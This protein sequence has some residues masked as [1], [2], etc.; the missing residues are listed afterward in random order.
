MAQDIGYVFEAR[1]VVDQFRGDSM[2]EDM[3][4]D[5][6]GDDK[7]SVGEGLPDD[8]PDRA[9]GQRMKRWPT[10]QKDLARGTARSPALE[11]GHERLADVVW[12]G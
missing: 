10:A 12:E 3:A 1:T 8:P 9:G 6:R 11:V 5:A 2:P 4:G 7:A